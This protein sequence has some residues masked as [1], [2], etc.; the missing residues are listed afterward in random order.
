[1]VG[2]WVPFSILVVS[3]GLPEWGRLSKLGLGSA[4]SGPFRCPVGLVRRSVF[5]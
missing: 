3:P 1:M 2:W 4:C 5:W